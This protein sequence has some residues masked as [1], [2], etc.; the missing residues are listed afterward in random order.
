MRKWDPDTCWLFSLALRRWESGFQKGKVAKVNFAAWEPGAEESAYQYHLGNLT[1][2]LEI[3]G[4]A[5]DIVDQQFGIQE[6][7]TY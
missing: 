1:S 6:C 4:P 3:R 5:S 2:S 7:V